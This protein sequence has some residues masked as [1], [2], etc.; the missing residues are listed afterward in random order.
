MVLYMDEYENRI[1]YEWPYPGLH[2][3]HGT[4]GESITHILRT[5]N[6]NL[7]VSHNMGPR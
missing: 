1:K 2:I 6:L 4:R 3:P 5:H 7:V